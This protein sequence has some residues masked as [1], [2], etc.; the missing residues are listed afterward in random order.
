LRVPLADVLVDVG[1]DDRGR[2]LR[3][4]FS[5]P[6]GAYATSVAREVCKN[7]EENGRN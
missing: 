5:L 4:G 7:E 6:A 1:E 2:F 3:L